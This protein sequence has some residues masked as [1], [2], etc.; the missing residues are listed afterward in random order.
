MTLVITELRD[1]FPTGPDPSFNPNVFSEDEEEAMSA[2]ERTRIHTCTGDHAP[3]IA[4]M[5][6]YA[7]RGNRFSRSKSQLSNHF[8]NSDPV[9]I[10]TSTVPALARAE[11]YDDEF[12]YVELKETNQNCETLRPTSIQSTT[13][14]RFNNNNQTNT[15]V[16][17]TGVPPSN[18]QG[19]HAVSPLCCE[20]SVPA[21]Q[22]PKNA[23][24]PSDIIFDRPPV[25][26]M[27]SY[28]TADYSNTVSHI[29]QVKSSLLPEHTN[30]NGVSLTLNLNQEHS[31]SIVKKVDLLTIDHKINSGSK[32]VFKTQLNNKDVTIDNNIINTSKRKENCLKHSTNLIGLGSNKEIKF[33]DE[34]QTCEINQGSST[35]L[36]NT[37]SSVYLTDSMVRS[38]SVGYLDLV[39]AQLLPCNIALHML[40]KDAPKR[41]VL[42]NRKNKQRKHK[43]QQANVDMKLDNLKSP[44]LSNCGKS[45]SLDSSDLFPSPDIQSLPHMPNHTEEAI[46]EPNNKLKDI[47]NHENTVT[48]TDNNVIA[49]NKNCKL[50]LPNGKSCVTKRKK[51][52][53]E[54][55]CSSSPSKKDSIKSRGRSKQINSPNIVPNRSSVEQPNTMPNLATMPARHNT[56]L[57]THALNTLESLLTRLR[58]M[59]DNKLT[60]PSSPRLPRS[61]PASPAPAKK[62]KRPQSASPIRKHLLNSPL[63]GRRSRKSKLT[64]SSDDEVAASSD[65]I[66]GGKNYK[67]LETFQK[68]QL[69]QKVHFFL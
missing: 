39:D 49:S 15:Y 34:E 65:E 68:A 18:G 7:Q 64:E 50:L 56:P 61:S 41:L 16:S 10:S 21:L 13:Q 62:G 2:E 24:A 8:L 25:Q 26:T 53:S 28:S 52:E 59:D 12:P 66:I 67:D 55:P 57:H 36:A 38:C 1:D 40:R 30:K 17:R 37:V 23:V 60:P 42:V 35:T 20:G 3:P 31:K 14:A 45:K 48:K 9:L 27:V 69:R 5:S 44:K 43:K 4:P 29:Q 11:S 22:S 6:P 54:T 19:R 51:S 46:Q 32:D 33:I 58:D 63:L 47:I